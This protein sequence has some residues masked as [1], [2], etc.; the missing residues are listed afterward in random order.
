MTHVKLV[1]KTQKKEFNSDWY[2]GKHAS[3]GFNRLSLLS[4]GDSFIRFLSVSF[5]NRSSGHIFLHYKSLSKGFSLRHMAW[6]APTLASNMSYKHLLSSSFSF[7]VFFSLIISSAVISPDFYLLLKIFPL[8]CSAFLFTLPLL[9]PGVQ[10]R[11]LEFMGSLGCLL[12]NVWRGGA[13]RPASVQ[14]PT[15][16]EQRPLLHRK[17]SHLSVLQCYTMPSIKWVCHMTTTMWISQTSLFMI[18]NI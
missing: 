13:V 17:E 11:Q 9:L 10:P 6:P 15:T 7:F 4:L 3:C 8:L 5:H 18:Q 16:T 14:Q 2:L 12:Q 1:G